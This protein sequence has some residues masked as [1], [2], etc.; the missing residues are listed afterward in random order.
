M[1]TDRRTI[2]RAAA[3]TAPA[4]TLATAAPAFAVSCDEPRAPQVCKHPGEG[5][6]T[7]DLY[8]RW[9][10]QDVVAVTID[11]KVATLTSHGWEVKGQKDSRNWHTVILFFASGE[12]ATYTLAFPPHHIWKDDAAED[13]D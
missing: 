5:K 4:V 7:K 13:G 11:G 2:L 8:V 3:W 1:N 6:N 10:D 12:T 9:T